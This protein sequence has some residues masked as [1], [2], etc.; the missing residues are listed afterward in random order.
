MALGILG[1]TWCAIQAPGILRLLKVLG[2]LGPTEW[3]LH[4][5]EF[6][7]PLMD[8]EILGPTRWELHTLI[9]N[10]RKP[11]LHCMLFTS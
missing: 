10:L 8:L 4:P 1:P 2:L 7:M 5:F 11:F 9:C 3:D 6:L